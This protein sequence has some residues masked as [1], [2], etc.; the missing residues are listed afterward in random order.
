MT[1]NL[2]VTVQYNQDFMMTLPAEVIKCDD[3]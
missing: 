3:K 2:M 1:L